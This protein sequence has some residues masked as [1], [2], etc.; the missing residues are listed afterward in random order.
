MN[1][2]KLEIMMVNRQRSQIVDET[3]EIW[4]SGHLYYH[5]SLDT[6]V[7]RFVHPLVVSLVRNGQIKAFFFVRDGLGGPHIRLRLRVIPDARD[8]V[9]AAMRQSAQRFL[10]LEPSTRSLDE[11]TIRRSNKFIMAADPHEIDDSVYPDNSF[12]VMP[13]R[14]EIE[15]YGGSSRFRLS[16]DFFTLS[17][18]AAVE[19]LSKYG[20]LSRSAQLAHAFRLLLQ[21]ALGFAA[22][23][24]ELCDLLRYGVDSWGEILPK[25]VDKGDKVARHQRDV[26]LRLFD[27]SL[28]EVRSLQVEAKGFGGAQDFLILGAR[29][30]SGAIGTADRVTRARIGGSQLHM[31]ATRL[32]LSNAEEVYI[33]RLLM[34]TLREL[35]TT[36]TYRKDLSWLGDEVA[37]TSAAEALSILLSPALAALTEVPISPLTQE[38]R[39]A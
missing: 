20:E 11:E 18:V 33:S 26:F 15:R 31:T 8:R 4:V 19:F 7:Q 9:L 23:E 22:D 17:S 32:G 38:S 34:V 13:F 28:A 2:L 29:R 24:T 39:R 25:V 27:K 6:I 14:P 10:D 3:R 35:R 12:H 37:E 30:L 5:Q 36:T 21:Q 1:P 16:L